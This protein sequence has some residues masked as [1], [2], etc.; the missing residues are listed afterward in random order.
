[1]IKSDNDAFFNIRE[2]LKGMDE[3]DA[4]ALASGYIDQNCSELDAEYLKHA[5]A[6]SGGDL[7]ELART[8]AAMGSPAAQTVLGTALLHG[9]FIDKD[10]SQGLF[11]LRRAHNNGNLKASIMLGGA[12]LDGQTLKPDV[13]KSLAYIVPAAE[14]G[15]TTAQYIFANLLIEG[16]GIEQDE[17]Q[18]IFWLRRAA[19][20][21]NDKARQML[22]DNDLSLADE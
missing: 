6:A 17:E 10:V 18:G 5:I 16:D 21:G 9:R 14:S 19:E 13:K 20:R 1:M 7:Q 11:W 3:A 12:Y 15:D 8:Y 4:I 22:L 2:Q